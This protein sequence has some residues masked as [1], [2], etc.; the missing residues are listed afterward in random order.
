MASQQEMA[1]RD[2]ERS[3]AAWLLTLPGPIK[4]AD[5]MS[6]SREAHQKFDPRVPF[7]AFERGL[8]ACGYEIVERKRG[9]FAIA[10]S[11]AM[12]TAA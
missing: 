3:V 9:V 12:R 11:D 7:S 8:A 2:I 5:L 6:A 4:A 10:P 1:M